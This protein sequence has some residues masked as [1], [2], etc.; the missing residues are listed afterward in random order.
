VSSGFRL[1]LTSAAALEDV[2]IRLK[3]VVASERATHVVFAWPNVRVKWPPTAWRL[4]RVDDDIQ[5]GYAA[6]APGRWR[7]T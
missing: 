1:L 5:H 3:V 4:G 6:K 7:S 2:P